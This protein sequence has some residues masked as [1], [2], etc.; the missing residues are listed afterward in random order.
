[1]RVSLENCKEKNRY[2]LEK[3]RG[4]KGDDVIVL[5]ND[6]YYKGKMKDTSTVCYDIN[7]ETVTVNILEVS[8][9]KY[10]TS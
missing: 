4:F 7:G 5:H 10:I 6:K 8:I 3:T 9:Y 1:M 2:R